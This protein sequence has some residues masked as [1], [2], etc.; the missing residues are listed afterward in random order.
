MPLLMCQTIDEGTY[1]LRE[2]HEG[3]CGSH[4]TRTSLTFK[5]L[6]NGYFW[7]IMK[8]NAL[9]L[10]KRCEKC[11]RHAH[12]P[13]KPS[14]EQLTLEVAWPFNQRGIDIL[15]LFSIALG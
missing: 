10:V 2:L 3:I 12:V 8:A 5:A 1:V 6:R 14:L 4:A 11:Q 13:R 7:P 9:D 15:G